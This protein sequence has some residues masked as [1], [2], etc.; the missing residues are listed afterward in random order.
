MKLPLKII[1]I[2][3]HLDKSKH[4]E[5]VLEKPSGFQSLGTGVKILGNQ[6]N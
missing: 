6:E 1:G 2:L 4:V 5:D 3:F